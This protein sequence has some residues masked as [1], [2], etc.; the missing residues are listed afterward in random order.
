MN[1]AVEKR[2]L[3]VG[4]LTLVL[5][6]LF[7]LIVI[8][9]AVLLALDGSRLS[10]LARGE[11]SEQVT[12]TAPR[13]PIVDRHGTALALSAQAFSIY[14]RPARLFKSSSAAERARL[15]G[16]LALR[17]GEL[18]GR[19]ERAA[20]FVWLA[21]RIPHA[22]AEQVEALGLDGI[23]ALSE[24]KRY[25]PESNLAAEV[26][27]KAGAD[28]QGLSGLELQYDRAMRGGPVA[29]REDRDALGH[30][31][32]D[33]P[34][35]WRDAAP[36]ARLELTI[37]SQIQARAETAL[38]SEVKESGARRGIAVVLDPFT[39]EL[40]AMAS[41]ESNGATDR[42]HNPAV[43]DVFEPGSTIKGILAAIAL[44]DR[45]VGEHQKVFCENGEWT[46]FGK[47]IHDHG[48]HQWLDL[49]EIVEVSS[50][51]GA[52]KVALRLG[53]QR[54]YRGLR[55]FGFG[56]PTGIDLPGETGGIV[57][58]ARTWQQIDLANHG[59]GQGV[60]V[61]AIQLASAYGAI[62]NG[63]VWMRPFVVKAAYDAD[64]N[65]IFVHTPQALG[66]IISPTVAHNANVILRSVVNGEDGTG[67]RAAIDD[68][69]V[70]GKTGTA[71][72]INASTGAYYQDRLV[73]SFV[74]FV[75]ADNPRLVV[76][77]VLEDVGHGHMGGLIA[78]PVFGE[79]AAGALDRLNVA[80]KR[81]AYDSASL[82]PVSMPSPESWAAAET[83]PAPQSDSVRD[84]RFVPDFR[85]LSLRAA[86]RMAAGRELN[87][88]VYGS[89]YVL[90]QR[91][92]A[93]QPLDGMPIRLTLGASDQTTE[94]QQAVRRVRPARRGGA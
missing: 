78:A 61:T 67:R 89:G 79:I 68:F 74:G 41:V 40:M 62:A 35:E 23:G 43:Q 1:V 17:P 84:T 14:A 56:R 29:L 52:A 85:G 87:V 71:Q 64:G 81:P 34:L 83:P 90:V 51:I 26:V 76:L 27:G 91:P 48:R 60:A 28:D 4:V 75:P 86:L 65:S 16:V 5:A 38:A 9:I 93:G 33:S 47:Q 92:A 55:A 7:A 44:E 39:G 18:A 53:A 66:R 46:L 20:H 42:L 54:Y 63:G 15:A 30:A 70:A 37:D 80:S 21:R 88:Q 8:R 59:F 58:P 57:R 32:L 11:H 82:L 72:M 13:G 45:A 94:A 73:G 31:I 12:L 3:R 6:G 22:Q 19:L 25:Y 10:S 69:V 36:G 2:R 50:N 77:V 49:Q 24:Y